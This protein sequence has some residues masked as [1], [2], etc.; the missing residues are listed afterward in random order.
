W[1]I[2]SIATSTKSKGGHWSHLNIISTKDSFFFYL[3]LQIV[4]KFSQDQFLHLFQ[5]FVWIN[6]WNNLD[7]FRKCLNHRVQVWT[8]CFGYIFLSD[9]KMYVFSLLHRIEVKCI[10]SIFLY[11]S[12]QGYGLFSMNIEGTYYLRICMSL[13]PGTFVMR[14]Y[15]RRIWSQNIINYRSCDEIDELGQKYFY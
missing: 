14:R 9:F 13:I 5:Y 12:Y 6:Y 2:N 10:S 11:I 8:N 15:I 1:V 3:R 7:T 4:V